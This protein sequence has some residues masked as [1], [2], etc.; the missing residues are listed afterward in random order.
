[1]NLQQ[2]YIVVDEDKQLYKPTGVKTT[3][4]LM[5]GGVSLMVCLSSS[6]NID[7]FHVND[8]VVPPKVILV[9]QIVQQQDALV[10]EDIRLQWQKDLDGMRCLQDNWDDDGAQAP[11]VISLVNTEDFINSLDSEIARKIS[12]YPNVFGAVTIKLDT[13]KGRIVCEMGDEL[14]SYFVKRPD[15]KNEYHSFE[16]MDKAHL[17]V[18]RLNLATLV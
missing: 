7:T 13:S 10:L 18:L 14:M 9:Q 16:P 3:A 4:R 6:I 1:M 2:F 15:V 5:V 8:A 17:D 12:L 11:D